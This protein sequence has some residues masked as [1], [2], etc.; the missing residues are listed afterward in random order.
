MNCLITDAIIVLTLDIIRKIFL[1]FDLYGHGKLDL[2]I[3]HVRAEKCV[4]SNKDLSKK[5]TYQRPKSPR[6]VIEP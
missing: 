3:V 2:K 1:Y 6:K 5:C 4:G